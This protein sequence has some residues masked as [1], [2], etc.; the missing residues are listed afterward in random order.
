MVK[1]W[2]VINSK[3]LFALKASVTSPQEDIG[4]AYSKDGK[5]V[6]ATAGGQV[7]RWDTETGSPLPA[8]SYGK[9]S[10]PVTFSSSN[11][12]ATSASQ[13]GDLMIWETDGNFVTRMQI[14]GG[15]QT[16]AFSKDSAWLAAAGPKNGNIYLFGLSNKGK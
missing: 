1:I 16:L 12:M 11:L 3:E 8:L 15:I 6:A 2:D 4:V 14:G 5:T 9:G 13:T 7:S 10:S